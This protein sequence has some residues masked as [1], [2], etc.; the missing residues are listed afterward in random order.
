MHGHSRFAA[1][2]DCEGISIGNCVSHGQGATGVGINFKD[3][4]RSVPQNR[5]CVLDGFVEEFDGG[6][7]NV[8]RVPVFRN[9]LDWDDLRFRP[10]LAADRDDTI[11]RQ[12][13]FYASGKGMILNALGK[14]QH[15]V[16]DQ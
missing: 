8:E 14:I 2:D 12:V 16:F 10:R 1:T 5:L 11:D 7:A 15:V 3:T 4:H 6:W 13:E 9:L